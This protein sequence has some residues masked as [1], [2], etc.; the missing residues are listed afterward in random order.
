MYR[1]FVFC[2]LFAILLL[3]TSCGVSNVNARKGFVAFLD[4]HHN[5]KYDI[6]TFKSHFN[7]A[8]MNPNIYWVELA[9]KENPEI[10]INFEWDAKNKELYV[11]NYSNKPDS[12][13]ALTD[14]LLQE[15]VLRKKLH[16]VLDKDVLDMDVNVF[17]HTISITLADDPSLEDLKYFSNKICRVIDNYPDTWTSEAHVDFKLKTEVKGFYELI[18]K[19]NTYDDN[20]ESYRYYPNAVVINNYGSVKA[21]RIDTLIQKEFSNASSP[22]Y[23]KDIWVNQKNLKSLI[24]AF[25]KHEPFKDKNEKSHLTEGVGMYQIQMYYPN[26]LME[27]LTYIDYNTIDREAMRSHLIDQL[28][29]DYTYLIEHS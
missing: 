17:N 14:Y 5:N 18:V 7:A 26:L 9:L 3:F 27:S 19:P 25:E 6:I 8:N 11:P 2:I 13:T 16:E 21:Q 24:I 29:L 20:K 28:P 1:F 10:V 23:L 22:I 4:T 15:V 12:I